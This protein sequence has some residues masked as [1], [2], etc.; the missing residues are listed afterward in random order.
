MLPARLSTTSQ[1]PL[2]TWRRLLA[3]SRYPLPATLPPSSALR[4]LCSTL[5]LFERKNPLCHIFSVYD[6][7]LVGPDSAEGFASA[8]GRRGRTRRASFFRPTLAPL[9]RGGILTDA[10]PP[11]H[12]HPALN[13]TPHTF[14]RRAHKHQTQIVHA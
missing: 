14:A 3:L 6:A 10:M 5:G 13:Q 1:R 4:C 7:S 9:L 12:K 8:G 11:S 2:Y